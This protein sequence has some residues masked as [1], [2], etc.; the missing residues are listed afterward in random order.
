[1]RVSAAPLIAAQPAAGLSHP[2]CGVIVGLGIGPF[3]GKAFR[4][5]HMGHTNAPMV[6]GALG[7]IEMGLI[8]LRI[9]HGARGVQQAVEYLGA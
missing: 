3:S 9:P 4:I 2:E 7:A 5:A 8:A 1:M 6:L